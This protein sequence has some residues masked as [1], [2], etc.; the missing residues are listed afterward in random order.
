MERILNHNIT[1]NII[2]EDRYNGKDFIGCSSI[3]IFYTERLIEQCTYDI[4]NGKVA[5][6]DQ[7][8]FAS[9]EFFLEYDS[10][11]ISPASLKDHGVSNPV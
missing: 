2:I 3:R 10:K 9:P 8:V 5:N 6:L 4:I 7:K 11:Q 1:P